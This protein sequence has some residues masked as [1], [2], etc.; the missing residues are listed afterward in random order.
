MY[1]LV[2]ENFKSLARVNGLWAVLV[3]LEEFEPQTYRFE[4]DMQ[5]IFIHHINTF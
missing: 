4:G 1:C 2:I 5:M 3:C